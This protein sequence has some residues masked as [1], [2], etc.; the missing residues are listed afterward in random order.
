MAPAL[1]CAGCIYIPELGPARASKLDLIGPSGS[2]K[3]IQVGVTSRDE[4][5][6]RLGPPYYHTEHQRALGFVFYRK[7]G[8]IAGLQG[9]PCGLAGPGPDV[10]EEDL[11]TEFDESGVLRRYHPGPPGDGVAWEDF[12][13]GIPDRNIPPGDF[14]KS[15]Y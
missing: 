13:Q 10:R 2:G 14:P 9:G 11:W 3:P 15:P 6:N 8:Y 1:L 5:V 7:L 4:V 12:I